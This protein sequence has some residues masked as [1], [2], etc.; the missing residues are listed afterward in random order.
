M[1]PNRAHGLV[2]FDVGALSLIVLARR[3]M[4]VVAVLII[5][6]AK[7]AVSRIHS[8]HSATALR[9]ALI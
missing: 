1:T 7:Y 9:A 5:G 6:L 3:F 2:A 8:G 4:Y